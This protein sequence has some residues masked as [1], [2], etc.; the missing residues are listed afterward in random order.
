MEG[1]DTYGAMTRRPLTLLALLLSGCYTQ[2]RLPDVPPEVLAEAVR[3]STWVGVG[4]RETRDGDVVGFEREHGD[5]FDP[6]YSLLTLGLWYMLPAQTDV[7]VEPDGA[8]S[9]LSVRILGHMQFL[10]VIPFLW[11]SERREATLAAQIVETARGVHEREQ[12]MRD[13]LKQL[14]LRALTL[15]PL[16]EKSMRRLAWLLAHVAG[17]RVAAEAWYRKADERATSSRAPTPGPGE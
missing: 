16:P 14:E 10:Y 6:L 4:G 8:G 3:T 12:G 17:D 9:L 13:E 2:V 15:E 1:S 7:I 11:T 5:M